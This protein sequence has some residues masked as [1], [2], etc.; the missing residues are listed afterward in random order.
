MTEPKQLSDAELADCA[1]SLEQGLFDDAA[2]IAALL[3]HIAW[4]EGEHREEKRL[5]EEFENHYKR[6][7]QMYGD[8]VE[9]TRTR[10]VEVVKEL[11]KHYKHMMG[12]EQMRCATVE[13]RP[14]AR[15]RIKAIDSKLHAINEII[16]AL[17]ATELG[18]K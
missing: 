3:A 9:I 5:H 7:C 12:V 18:G 2:D 8:K 4:L 14:A 10:P 13:F 6:V 15:E 1:D 11:D 17:K 16:A